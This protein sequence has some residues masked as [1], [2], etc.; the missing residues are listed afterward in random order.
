MFRW[1]KEKNFAVN[2]IR[3]DPFNWQK[4]FVLTINDD[5]HERRFKDATT[6]LEYD[7]AVCKDTSYTKQLSPW[8]GSP[9]VKV[10]NCYTAR[11]ELI[12]EANNVEVVFFVCFVLH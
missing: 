1:C 4:V 5:S 12:V 11:C 6:Q 10:E 2:R 3:Q 9:N 8:S 7:V